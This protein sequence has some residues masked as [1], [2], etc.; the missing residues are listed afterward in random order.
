MAKKE[1]SAQMRKRHDMEVRRLRQEW[2]K[3]KGSK[4]AK[5]AGLEAAEAELQTRH[6]AEKLALA[7]ENGSS[8]AATVS[9]SAS[10]SSEANE[11]AKATSETDALMA[12]I[13]EMAAVPQQPV[14]QERKLT[15]A[16]R[17][18]M[19]REAAEAAAVAEAEAEAAEMAD[20]KREEMNEL[21][22]QLGD[23]WGIKSIAAD[24]HCLYSAIADQ[25]RLS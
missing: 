8:A 22:Q 23:D 20:L 9:D 13:S 10:V 5:K 15:K 6:E 4:Q 25:L 14:Q 24:G 2:K 21:K 16:Q 3:R 11:A 1:T 19:R 7:N 17:R 12:R 18:K